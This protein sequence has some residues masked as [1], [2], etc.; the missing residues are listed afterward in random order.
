MLDDLLKIL[1]EETSVYGVVLN[2][3]EKEKDAIV[4]SNLDALRTATDQKASLF[5][6]IQDLETERQTL[7]EELGGV[8]GR[9]G[10]ELSLRKLIRGAEEPHTSQLKDCR[11]HLLRLAASISEINAQ[12]R[13]LITHHLRLVRSSLSFLNNLTV[14]ST[15]YHST[16]KM[17]MTSG[18]SG[19]V[20]SGEY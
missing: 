7:M 8:L 12:N 13:A 3:A 14:S 16:G 17:L 1:R 20:L 19:R 18:R 10:Q 11:S 15:V 4:E 6:R 9:P 5:T 2:L